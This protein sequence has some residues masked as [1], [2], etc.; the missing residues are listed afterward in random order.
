MSPLQAGLWSTPAYIGFVVGSIV[1]PVIVRHVAPAR[2]MPASLV[3]AAVGLVMLTQTDRVAGLPILV[4]GSVVFTLGLA[5]VTTLATDIMVGTA[6]P[7]RA[8]AAAAISETSSEFGGA[9]GIAV[10]GSIGTAVYRGIMTRTTPDGVPRAVLDDVQDTL[11]A[12]VAAVS[13][14]AES[15]RATLLDVARD[16][17]GRAFEIVNITAAVI[18]VAAGVIAALLVRPGHPEAAATGERP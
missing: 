15:D 13:Q 3:L 9:L 12:A 17:F 14:I 2:V 16:A 7:E 1:T 8:G 5:P 6:P 11:G 18:L 10:L 4:A